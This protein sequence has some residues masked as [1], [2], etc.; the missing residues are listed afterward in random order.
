MTFRALTAV[1][2]LAAVA[3]VEVALRGRSLDL[4]RRLTVQ[5]FR[6]E[7]LR[8][9]ATRLRLTIEAA[10]PLDARPPR[11]VPPV[12]TAERSAASPGEPAPP[13]EAQSPRPTSPLL[14]WGAGWTDE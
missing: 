14:R 11:S 13:A 10:V 9:R 12:R 2:L 4:H 6:G 8:E 1:L 3:N 7:A 5:H